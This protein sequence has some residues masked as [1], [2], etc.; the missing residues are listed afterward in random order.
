MVVSALWLT[1]LFVGQHKGSESRYERAAEEV[2]RFQPYKHYL[3]ELVKDIESLPK[4]SRNLRARHSGSGERCSCMRGA[5]R[6][7]Y[8]TPYCST[9]VTII[10]CTKAQ[11]PPQ[12]CERHFCLMGFL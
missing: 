9:L 2:L 7:H 1:D 10:S 5:F 3:E 4:L 11:A 8:P 6:A 12:Q